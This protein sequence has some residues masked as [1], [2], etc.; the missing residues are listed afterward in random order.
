MDS[1]EPARVGDCSSTPGQMA[2][3]TAPLQKRRAGAVGFRRRRNALA[4]HVTA[5]PL[6]DPA[7]R[8]VDVIDNADLDPRARTATRPI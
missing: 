7:V 8:S 3:P 2:H 4:G 5:A 6:G 1:L